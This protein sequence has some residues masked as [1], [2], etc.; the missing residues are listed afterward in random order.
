[1]QSLLWWISSLLIVNVLVYRQDEKRRLLVQHHRLS[2]C[3]TE[4]WQF[5]QRLSFDCD[6][7]PALWTL[8]FCQGMVMQ[9]QVHYLQHTVV[10]GLQAATWKTEPSFVG[11]A[12]FDLG[13][14]IWYWLFNFSWLIM[15]CRFI[16]TYLPLSIQGRWNAYSA[17][18]KNITTWW[19]R[20]A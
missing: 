7:Q 18:P 2:D 20:H 10:S 14:L 4:S 3:E 19:L 17:W 5:Q 15:F 8:C 6:T 12:S 16:V 13:T 1:M 9:Q 11:H